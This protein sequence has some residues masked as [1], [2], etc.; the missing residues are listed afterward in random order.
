M[1]ILLFSTVIA[2]AESLSTIYHW[3]QKPFI[4]ICPESNV[5]VEEVRVAMQYWQSKKNYQH[6]G[7]TKVEEC[8]DKKHHTIQI[9]NGAN[10]VRSDSLAT[11][12]VTWY[13]YPKIDPN[14]RIKYVSN[15]R[16]NIPTS[17]REQ[18]QNII[19]HELGHAFGLGHSDHP[20]MKEYF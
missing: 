20:I 3:E 11:T 9:T 1:L 10:I 16:V 12:D 13:F 4:E 18:R 7:V 15:A 5:T 19:I 6:S 2:N 14:K 17:L 8:N